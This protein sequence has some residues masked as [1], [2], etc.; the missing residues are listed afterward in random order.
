MTWTLTLVALTVLAVAAVSAR[1]AGSPVTPAMLFVAAGLLL[2]PW[3]L[4][5]IDAPAGNS[6]VRTAAEATLTLVLFCDAARVDVKQLR[7]SIE[8]PL[9]LLGVGLPLT[10]A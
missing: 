7:R 1:L 6:A 4:D 9:R 10:I 8:M 3:A 5:G 2:G